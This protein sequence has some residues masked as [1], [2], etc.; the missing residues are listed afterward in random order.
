MSA[1]PNG[2]YDVYVCTISSWPQSYSLA[3]Q[4]K[5]VFSNP[6][7]GITGTWLKLGPWP[8]QVT[9][10]KIRL[11]SNGNIVHIAGIEVWRRNAAPAVA[12]V[13]T[14]PGTAQTIESDNQIVTR[15][16]SWTAQDAEGA[17]GK[18]YLYS[19]GGQ[20]D[21][22]LLPF[23]G[24]RLSVVYI[25]HPNLGTF[26]IE[27]DSKLVQTVDSKGTES[28]FGAQVEINGLNDG[29]PSTPLGFTHKVSP[30]SLRWI[31]RL[32]EIQPPSPGR[33]G[34]RVSKGS[35]GNKANRGNRAS[36]A[37]RVR[38]ATR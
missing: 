3:L 37:T 26:G 5:P 12:N 17:S 18:R 13:S 9:D 8:A 35:R 36:R 31:A 30:H 22:L 2:L 19:S 21:S 1:V 24:A 7:S 34:S 33:K 20:N 28:A 25:K 27:I 10:G 32:P 11:T 38:R 15:S 29:L 14:S 23:Q 4:G 16:G 6:D